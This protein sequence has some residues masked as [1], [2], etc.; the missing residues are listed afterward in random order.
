MGTDDAAEARWALYRDNPG[1]TWAQLAALAG[2]S[3]AAFAKTATRGKFRERLARE[4]LGPVDPAS[5]AVA[6]VEAWLAGLSPEDL[7]AVDVARI[8]EAVSAF[9]AG[10]ITA[11]PAPWTEAARTDALRAVTSGLGPLDETCPCDLRRLTFAQLEAFLFL[12]ERACGSAVPF[13]PAGHVAPGSPP[14]AEPDYERVC[15]EGA[16][17]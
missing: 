12:F 16:A 14:V 6:T 10:T 17:S 15:S 1:M 8:L 5:H 4:R 3:E 9:R 7:K 13:R 11:K 2:C